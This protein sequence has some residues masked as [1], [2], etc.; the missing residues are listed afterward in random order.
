MLDGFWAPLLL[1]VVVTVLVV[2]AASLAA[3]RGGPIWGGL[4]AA[5]PISAGPA[6]VLLAIQTDAAFVAQSA[7]SGFAATAALCPFLL[8]VVRLGP[9]WRALPTVMLAVLAWIAAIVPIQLVPWSSW[10]ATL[11]NVAAFAIGC[12]LTRGAERLPI[13]RGTTRLWFDLP[14]RALTIGIVIATLVTISHHIGPTATGSWLGF[15]IGLA[16][17]TLVIHARSGGAAAAATMAVGLRALPG[18]ACAL[19]VLHL[20]ASSNVVFALLAAVATSIAY[21]LGFMVWKMRARATASN[22]L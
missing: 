22:P 21:A 12:R 13:A 8:V 9:R 17:M 6:Y 3:E 11:L 14:L 20:T 19:M 4:I 18:F 5:L 1:K 2:I 15:P 7:L 16:S 10:S